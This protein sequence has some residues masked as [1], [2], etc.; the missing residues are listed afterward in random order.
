MIEGASTTLSAISL[1]VRPSGSRWLAIEGGAGDDVVL[2]Q[3]GER[4]LT[5]GAAPPFWLVSIT[6]R[7]RAID[8]TSLTC[9]SPRHLE[10]F[11]HRTPGGGFRVRVLGR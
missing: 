1:K 9:R 11:G 10:D 8:A 2:D 4:R 7:C 3:R 6:S 5:E